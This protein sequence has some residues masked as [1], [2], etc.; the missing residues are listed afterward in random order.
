M[1]LIVTEQQ[2]VVTDLFTHSI[3]S[4]NS[5]SYDILTTNIQQNTTFPSAV[6]ENDVDILNGHIYYNETFNHSLFWHNDD[7]CISYEGNFPYMNVTCD[8]V[9]GK[10]DLYQLFKGEIDGNLWI[11]VWKHF[12]VEKRTIEGDFY[13][14]KFIYYH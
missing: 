2:P 13:L 5:I 14:Q 12:D 7:F 3:S 6:V 1:N 4:N 10:F 9:I 11:M 8:S